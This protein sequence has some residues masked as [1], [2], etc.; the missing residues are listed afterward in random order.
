MSILSLAKLLIY[1]HTLRHLKPVQIYRRLWFKVY[2]PRIDV[3]TA[4]DVNQEV[5]AWEAP[6][7]KAC[8]MVGIDRFRFLNQEYTLPQGQ[9][10]DASLAKLWLYNLHYFDDLNSS[11]ASERESWH[12]SLLM[13]WVQANPPT[14]G[15]GWEPYPTSLRIVN[16]VKWALSGRRLPSECLLSLAVQTR[17]L[18]KRME[19]HLLGNHLFANAKAL[20]FAGAFFEGSEAGGWLRTGMKIIADLL[21]EQILDDGGHFERS[22]M[23][24]ALALEDLLDLINLSKAYKTSF[25]TFKQQVDT[26]PCAVEKMASW[27]EIMCH[28]DGRISFFNDSALSIAPSLSCLMNYSR[29]LDLNESRSQ[30][31]S[32]RAVNWLNQSGYIRISKG[33]LTALL[34]VA[35]IGPNY[36]P[37]HAHADTLSFELSLDAQRVFVN[38]GTSGYELSDRRDYER[39]TAAHNTV[40]VDRQNSS[41]TWSS[42]RVARRAYPFGLKVE[43]TEEQ[44]SVVCSHSGY[45]RLKGKNIHTREWSMKNNRLMVKDAVEGSH[46]YAVARFHVHPDVKVLMTD[47]NSFAISLPGGRKLLFQVI[48]GLAKLVSSSYAPEFG[49]IVETSCIEVSLENGTS[50]VSFEI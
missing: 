27:L 44:V 21:P 37:G 50:C 28:P 41:E 14:L 6:A 12:L 3:L 29:R 23:Y 33:S 16:W 43:G 10:E 18:S 2:H 39:S 49:K 45:R 22:P 8:S 4:L 35:K 26:W 5:G 30:F 7:L 9:W 25:A 20:V 11:G 17:W 42:F 36:L 46:G 24:H 13:C 31:Q 32:T 38:V 48:T 40:E 1:W 34:D 47:S 15:T 19:Y